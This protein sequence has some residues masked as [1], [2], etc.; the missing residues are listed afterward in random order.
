MD[1]EQPGP[2]RQEPEGPGDD[3]QRAEVSVY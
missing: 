1:G 3:E 2:C